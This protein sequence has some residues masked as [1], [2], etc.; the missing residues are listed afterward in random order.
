MFKDA[1]K[2]LLRLPALC[3]CGFDEEVWR[4]RES[5]CV[6]VCVCVRFTLDINYAI[7]RIS[8]WR[9]RNEGNLNEALV[10]AGGR[11][12]KESAW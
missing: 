12:M 2:D 5:E 3:V 10:L 7:L 9:R 1:F 11:R 6:R 8:L 4:E